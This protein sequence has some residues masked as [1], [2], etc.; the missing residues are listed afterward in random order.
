MH[1]AS[2]TRKVFGIIL[3]V[4]PLLTSTA[5]RGEERTFSAGLGFEFA[6]GK[7]GT[8]TRS[9]SVYAPFTAAYYPTERLLTFTRAVPTSTPAF[10]AVQR[11][12]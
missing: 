12:R 6:S 3:L 9:E 5:A 7:Y 2:S 11:G 8:G 4:T 1:L 10:T